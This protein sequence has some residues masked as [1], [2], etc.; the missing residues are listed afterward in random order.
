[1][2]IKFYESVFILKSCK[3]WSCSFLMSHIK[4][5]FYVILYYFLV[6]ILHHLQKKQPNLVNFDWFNSTIDGKIVVLKNTRSVMEQK[7]VTI[8]PSIDKYIIKC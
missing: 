5:C 7:E 8:L 3:A 2:E 6:L 1:M 4:Q